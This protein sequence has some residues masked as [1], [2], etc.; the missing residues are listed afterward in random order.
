MFFI[1]IIFI[2][3]RNNYSFFLDVFSLLCFVVVVVVSLQSDVAPLRNVCLV[4]MHLS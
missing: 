3:I 4:L 2:H 1:F